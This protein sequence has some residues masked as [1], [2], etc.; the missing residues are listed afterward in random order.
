MM[1]ENL[2]LLMSGFAIVLQP[3][4]FIWLTVGVVLGTM[5]GVLPGIGPISGVALLIPLTYNMNPVTALMTMSGL[6]YGAMYGGSTTSIL[7]NVP[8]ENSS[9]VTCLDG[10]QLAK[11]GRAGSALGISA[12]GSFVAGTI[13]VILLQFLAP[14]LGQWALAFGPAEYFSLMLLGLMSATTLNEG[15]A[16]KGLMA[17]GLGLALGT[18]GIDLQTGTTRFTFGRLDLLDGID[19]LVLALGLFSIAEVLWEATHREGAAERIKLNSPYPTWKDIKE[20]AG[21]ILRGSSL[22]F[23]LGVLP[24]VGASTASF[25]SYAV[26]KQ[27]S[28]NPD[29][30]GKGALRGVAAP[31]SANNGASEGAL[32]SLLSL[33][34]P[35]SGTTAVMLGALM[36]FGIQPGPML[37]PKHPEIFWGIVAS[38]YIGNVMLLI[39][40]LPL[41]PLFAKILDIPKQLLLPL[42][43]VLS[44]IGVYAL[45]NSRTD[46]EM[47]LFFGLCGILMRVY[48]IPTPPMILALV[49][50]PMVEQSMRQA[51]T[52]SRGNWNTFVV[53]PISATLLVLALAFLLFPFLRRVAAQ[54]RLK[55]VHRA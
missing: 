25:V 50:G 11:K 36:M 30:F 52:I 20:S 26:E 13:G 4:N 51:L 18:I 7:L 19:F 15:S 32:V 10:F 5:I 21:A 22:G 37:I 12:I 44:S 8:G 6:Y 46:L 1:A 35:G 31:E 34:L 14:P 48:Q 49:L 53:H 42:I 29:E 23:F 17:V 40:N 16:S 38:M 41:V 27:I 43:V 9:V 3:L 33:G 47:M 24:G 2:H 28:K 54:S 39:L 55:G 45:S